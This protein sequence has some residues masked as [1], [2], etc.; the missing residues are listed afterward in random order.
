[1]KYYEGNTTTETTEI[2]AIMGN[3]LRKLSDTIGSSSYS[4]RIP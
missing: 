2:P 4:N 3:S 1:M